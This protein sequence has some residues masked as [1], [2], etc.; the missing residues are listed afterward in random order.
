MS[1]EF[2][3]GRYYIGDLSYVITDQGFEHLLESTDF[4]KSEEQI[5]KVYPVFTRN[6]AQGDGLF[7]DQKDR[8]YAVD[9]GTLGIMPFKAIEKAIPSHKTYG[10]LGHVVEFKHDFKVECKN[11]VF[12]FGDIVID[13]NLG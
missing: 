6:T 2:K 5:F 8:I 3:A 4:L 13:T 12:I 11:G 7:H 9:S 1:K 10:K